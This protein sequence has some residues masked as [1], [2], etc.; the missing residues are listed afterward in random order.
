[1]S[2]KGKGSR[3]FKKKHKTKKE[4]KKNKIVKLLN[5][6]V[7][8]FEHNFILILEQMLTIN[9]SILP[10]LFIVTKITRH[11]HTFFFTTGDHKAAI[12]IINK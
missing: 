6:K 3:D 5:I 11:V 4:V 2:L 9:S 10:G 7:L 1:M 8:D 12:K